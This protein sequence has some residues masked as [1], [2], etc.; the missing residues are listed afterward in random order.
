MDESIIKTANTKKSLSE[1]IA[2]RQRSLN[3][4]S[5]CNI[6][7]DPD[8]VLRK[9]GKDIKIYRELLCDP[10]VIACVQSRKAGVLSLEWEIARGLNK[11]KNIELLSNL[12]KKLDLY[13]LINDILDSVLWG[14][15]PIEIIWKK[16]G[17]LILPSELKAKPPE[18]F[19]YDADNN[20]RF[21]TKQNYFGELLPPKKFLCPQYNA[22]YDNPYGD[23]ILSKVFWQVVFKKGGLK[24][25]TIFTEKY[26]MPHIIGKHPRG[27]SQ[28]ETNN[29]A[30]ML[31]RMVQDAIAVIPDDSSVE[32]QEANKSSSAE[33]Y[34]KLINKM[35]AEI[36][37]AIIGQ[38]LTTEIGSTGSYAA[39]NTHFQVRQDIVNSDKKLVEKT[40]NQ[41][42]RWIY[43]L[44]FSTE[45]IPEFEL[46][47]EEDIDLNLA[48]RDK[49]LSESGV[50]FT[51]KYFIKNYGLDEEDFDIAEIQQTAQPVFSQFKEQENFQGQRQVDE[52][53][54]LI[55][56]QELQNQSEKIL[57][58]LIEMIMNGNSYSEIKEALKDENLN[59]KDFEKVLQ[60]ALF[61]C[62][63]EG[64]IDGLE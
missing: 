18:W 58:P 35:N 7:P 13:K 12:L 61:L 63:V 30:D 16:E 4:Y 40:I 43:E 37:K 21:K 55:S 41:L 27:A 11:D 48:Q 9:Q 22:S 17:S 33:I 14:F 62:E 50:K 34:E 26:G 54:D 20:L 23:R 1:E 15:Q 38:T 36:S 31:E 59:T 51:K 60:K 8:I 19:C 24:F 64:R 45:I 32:L 42:L 47:E 46:Y 10:H 25:W 3:F 57:S 56:N 49:T 2:T 5:L 6:L 52:L 44:N 39:S 28:E 53:F 29:L